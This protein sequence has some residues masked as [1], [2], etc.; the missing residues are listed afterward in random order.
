MKPCSQCGS[1]T[2]PRYEYLAKRPF[3]G[4][5]KLVQHSWCNPCRSRHNAEK[6]RKKK[7]ASR[8]QSAIR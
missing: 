4:Y 1:T 5:P 6:A 8:D 2:N 3:E 7:E